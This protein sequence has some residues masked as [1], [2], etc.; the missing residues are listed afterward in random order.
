MGELLVANQIIVRKGI[1]TAFFQLPPFC[2]VAAFASLPDIT[3]WAILV[4]FSMEC[5][6][7][8]EMSE[9]RCTLYKQIFL[10]LLPG[11]YINLKLCQLESEPCTQ[12]IL[13]LL[14]P[15]FHVQR[16]SRRWFLFC[17]LSM[18][19]LKDIEIRALLARKINWD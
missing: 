2:F 17:Q 8:P 10:F 3:R 9:M 12:S 4:L 18:M 6:N 14:P 5:T 15:T 13:G 16:I 11:S 7:I 1:T 19:V